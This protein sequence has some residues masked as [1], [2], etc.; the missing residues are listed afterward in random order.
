MNLSTRQLANSKTHQL[1]NLPT[2]NSPTHITNSQTYQLKNSPT[3]ITNSQ[4][5]QLKNSPTHITNS[6]TCRLKNSPT[7]II[8]SKTY[9]L[10]NLNC[11][12]CF[13]KP[14]FF[15]TRSSENVGE[16]VGKKPPFLAFHVPRLV[17]F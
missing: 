11:C 9:Q 16:K 1:A 10:K 6:Q 7:H 5:C 8:N 14:L 4:T 15:S 13:T 3:H 17:C 12:F 2:K